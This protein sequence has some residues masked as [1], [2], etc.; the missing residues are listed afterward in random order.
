M[1]F[2]KRLWVNRHTSSEMI[3]SI[4]YDQ[5]SFYKKFTQDLLQ[6]RDEVIIESPFISPNR[7]ELLFPVFKRLLANGVKIHI[8]TKDPSE[9]EDEHFKHQVTNEVLTCADM[10]I[11]I[12]F[13]EGHHRKIAIIDR[14]VLWEGSLNILSQNRSLEFMRRIESKILTE[15]L[16]KFLKLETLLF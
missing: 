9:H 15:Q 3:D 6:A 4:L 2:I 16:F 8:V 11:N 10:G 12:V 13:R 14:L 7:M 5:G 1:N